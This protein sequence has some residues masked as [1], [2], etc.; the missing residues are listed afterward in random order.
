ML[1]TGAVSCSGLVER[2][3][4]RRRHQGAHVLEKCQPSHRLQPKH[5]HISVQNLIPRA[6]MMLPS[7]TLLKKALEEVEGVIS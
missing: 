3:K 4:L 2:I 7:P 1:E 5:T 6:I